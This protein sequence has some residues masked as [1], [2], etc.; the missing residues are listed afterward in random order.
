MN[1]QTDVLIIGGGFAGV[2]IA[3][4]LAKSG[5]DTVLIDKKNYFEVTFAML[6]NVTN[7]QKT[8]N[9]P[10]KKYIDFIEGAF[11]QATVETMNDKEVKLSDGN[12]IGFNSVVIATGSRYPTLSLAKSNF[13]FDYDGRREEIDNEN[14]ALKSAES[15][16]IIGGGVVGVEFAGEIS[17][18]F[19]EKKITLAHGSGNL[20]DNFEPKMQQKAL[21]QLTA[22]GVDVKFNR[23]FE[24]DGDLYRCSKSKE[25]IKAEITY[26]CVGMVPNTEFIRAELPDILDDKGLIKV[27]RFM[28]VEGYNNIYALGDCS[29]LDISNKNGYIATVQGGMIASNLINSA[30][31]KKTKPYKNQPL[32]VVTTTGIDTGVAQLPFTV[33]TLKVLINMKQKDLGISNM[34]KVFGTVP[35]ELMNR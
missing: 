10:R 24:K 7:P 32:F 27:D 25:T 23:R 1:R 22:R 9:T 6:R 3:Q 17:S 30:K 21:E 18:A 35:D 11:V 5:I 29:D 8:G 4:K 26:V 13:A 33:T 2:S 28:K 15:V 12:T 34:Y 20:L 14:K 31:G 19:P 16:L